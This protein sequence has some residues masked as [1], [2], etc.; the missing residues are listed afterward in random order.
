MTTNYVVKAVATIIPF[1][2]I[3][4]TRILVPNCHYFYKTLQMGGFLFPAQLLFFNCAKWQTS[5]LA[6][7]SHMKLF[8]Q[9]LAIRVALQSA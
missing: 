4:P 2:K 5:S 3:P 7:Q 8:H 9:L 6:C 1:S